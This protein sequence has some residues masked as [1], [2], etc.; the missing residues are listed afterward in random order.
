LFY[1]KSGAIT[2]AGPA[3]ALPGSAPAIRRQAGDPCLAWI[4]RCS[5]RSP[6]IPL[7]RISHACG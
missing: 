2:S 6:S 3:P 7:S 4:A 5:G 1:H